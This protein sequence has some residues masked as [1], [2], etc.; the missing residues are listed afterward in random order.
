MSG[1][2][3]PL[4]PGSST[5][6]ADYAGRAGIWALYGKLTMTLPLGADSDSDGLPDFFE[7][8]FGFSGLSSTG[9][10]A[11]EWHID[12][13]SKST[14]LYYF[15]FTRTANAYRGYY[16]LIASHET[17]GWS[18]YFQLKGA[19]GTITFNTVN[20]TFTVSLTSFDGQET[21]GGTGS[22][23]RLSDGTIQCQGFTLTSSQGSSS[24]RTVQAFSLSPISGGRVAG[25]ITMTDGH[26]STPYAD[27]QS[28]HVEM[29]NPPPASVSSPAFPIPAGNYF[30]TR[31]NA[32]QFFSWQANATNASSYSFATLPAGLS[33]SAAGLISGTPTTPGTY[34]F[35]ITAS[36]ASGT[37]TREMVLYVLPSIGNL[38]WSDSFSTNPASRYLM[39]PA[40]NA[41]LGWSSGNGRLD[42]ASP[43]NADASQFGNFVKTIPNLS[44]S[45]GSSWEISVDVRLP[46]L[47]PAPDGSA[48]EAVGLGLVPDDPNA[49]L[50]SFDAN[51]LS[52]EVGHG[53]PPWE[54]PDGLSDNNFICAYA[55]SN[56]QDLLTVADDAP[57][58][59]Q[60]T[61]RLQYQA[62][63][64][65]LVTS[66]RTPSGSWVFTST[67]SLNPSVSGSVGAGWGLSNSSS[68]RVAMWA[69]SYRATGLTAGNIWLDN[70]T[71][72]SVSVVSPPTIDSSAQPLSTLA[73]TGQSVS[74]SVTPSGTGPFTYQWRLNGSPISG[75]TNSTYT[76]P[77]VSSSHAGSY[78]V[79]VSNSGGSV[80]SSAATLSLSTANISSFNYPGARS[81]Y[82][83]D[84]YGSQIVGFFDGYPDSNGNVERK[85]FLSQNGSWTL[86]HP[87]GSL[88]SEARGITASGTVVGYFRDSASKDHGY[89]YKN[90]AFTTQDYPTA[91]HTRIFGVDAS[92][93]SRFV[94]RF[95]DSQGVTRGFL[96][97]T[98]G[99]TP[100]MFPSAVETVAHG[101]AGSRVVGK[102][103]LVSDGAEFGFLWDGTNWTSLG[104]GRLPYA[105][106]TEGQAIGENLSP[107]STTGLAAYFVYQNGF[108]R[109]FTLPGSESAVPYGYDP[110]TQKISGFYLRQDQSGWNGLTLPLAF[111]TGSLQV[112]GRILTPS[113]TPFTNLRLVL[114]G[115]DPSAWGANA[116]SI[117]IGSTVTDTNGA[118]QFSLDRTKDYLIAA[119][120]TAT[121]AATGIPFPLNVF[122]D[123]FSATLDLGSLVAESTSRTVEVRLV[124][125]AA[126]PLAGTLLAN[127]SSAPLLAELDLV[128]DRLVLWQLSLL[129]RAAGL[130]F[131]KLTSPEKAGLRAQ[132]NR[133]W[134][135]LNW[136]NNAESSLLSWTF[137]AN[138]PAGLPSSLTKAEFNQIVYDPR[139]YWDDF[140]PVTF[141]VSRNGSFRYIVPVPA[142]PSTD[143]RIWDLPVTHYL[144][145]DGAIEIFL[146]LAPTTNSTFLSKRLDLNA[147]NL[148]AS[149]ANLTVR[150]APFRVSG[151]VFQPNGSTPL[152]NAAVNITG[153]GTG[154]GYQARI[155]TDAQGAFS[156]PAFA[157]S[158][159][160]ELWSGPI[161]G[162]A[163]VPVSSS[164]V[165]NV[166]LIAGQAAF[167]TSASV[168]AGGQTLRLAGTQLQTW[169]GVYLL[170]SPSQTGSQWFLSPSA[171]DP[172]LANGTWLELAIPSAVPTGTYYVGYYGY[173]NGIWT[174][175]VYQTP[176]TLTRNPAPLSPAA[177][178]S[179]LRGNLGQ[180]FSY[181]PVWSTSPTSYSATGLPA[182]LTNNPTTG[183]ISGTPTQA[184]Y[185]LVTQTASNS[186]GSTAFSFSLTIPGTS[187]SL[188]FSDDFS[189]SVTNRYMPLNFDSPA[190]LTITGGV[191]RYSCSS[192][193]SDGAIAALLP[194]LPLPLSSSWEISADVFMPSGWPTP[195][196]GVGLSLLP[197][198]STGTVETVAANRLNFKLARD[199]EDNAV[200]GNY[201]N[202][203]LYTNDVE[204]SPRNATNTTAT[205]AN[206]R[207]VYSATAKT[208]TAFYRT[209][210]S[211]AWTQLGSAQNLNPTTAGSL[212]QA[213]G[214]TTNS[215]LQLAFWGD[216]DATNGSAA[217]NICLDN[218]VARAGTVPSLSSQPTSTNVAAGQTAL[219]SVIATGSDPFTYQWRFNGTNLA[220]ATNAT[221]SLTNAQTN[222]AGPYSVVV[223]NFFG[224]VTSSVATLT[225]LTPPVVTNNPAF[226]SRLAGDS[227]I[228]SVA[229][230]GDGPFTYQWRLNGTNLASATNATL[231]LSG[232][233]ASQAGAYSVVVSGP[234][235]STTNG[236]A[237]VS[238]NQPL[239][240]F[241]DGFGSAIPGWIFLGETNRLTVTGGVLAAGSTLSSARPPVSLSL[242]SP[243]VAEVDAVLTSSAAGTASLA[244]SVHPE[245]AE[246]YTGVRP[247]HRL[248]LVLTPSGTN[249]ILQPVRYVNNVASNLPSVTVPHQAVRLRLAHAP[250]SGQLVLAWSPA[251]TGNTWSDLS[252]LPLNPTNS[253]VSNNLAT[254][255]NLNSTS[256]FRINLWGNQ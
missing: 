173:P 184:G 241:L 95:T 111:P 143:P 236:V 12:P 212:A 59:S 44:L 49:D 119:N 248:D 148:P 51:F 92:D 132:A 90:G 124:D 121:Q 85:G 37:D 50:S 239:L 240:P 234:G 157:S 156:F 88:R 105:V 145:G 204:L 210:P 26:P 171:R 180:A 84:S 74:F 233:V 197:Y 77:S 108:F 182:G 199:T 165:T 87:P 221:L 222:Q 159:E 185:F 113:N 188:P 46:L 251:S 191:A 166:S 225:I 177:L 125:D 217:Q 27:Y 172:N 190:S 65:S 31:A 5:Y 206:L 164:N 7:K 205:A 76:I 64:K 25:T 91:T 224:S 115:I 23:Q 18:G 131:G 152:T 229:A 213:W 127:A 93:D 196:A 72:Q 139:Y 69:D 120:P 109:T 61:L 170:E 189:S 253:S 11:D 122:A 158:G 133:I 40:A 243:W 227:T 16:T 245:S 103:R 73:A 187:L 19:T 208:L 116:S 24:A 244:L 192:S 130:T 161:F 178:P 8:S 155:R 75:A 146:G 123:P 83:S 3:R 174:N 96:R 175:I 80:T 216:S 160:W 15:T 198:T 39:V 17:L 82:G 60:A 220:A 33:G 42:Y 38:P 242:A 214:L 252:A 150:A 28:Y 9:T 223:S 163:Y 30:Y 41:S 228:L 4:S 237:L 141:E 2:L 129:Q 147:T 10:A 106:T 21:N 207:L 89:V 110:S 94:G 232:L 136:P 230:S 14:N 53:T 43:S 20:N 102:Y 186:G 86:L 140:N 52:L 162:N 211:A 101:V 249:R 254:L 99:W 48:Y 79:A 195:Y 81:T 62:S 247:A 168:I 149:P 57:S 219:F 117:P 135:E 179:G 36:N 100:L 128:S 151:R 114:H 215:S 231:S 34:W 29:S 32:G 138:S 97:T 47:S 137:L 78:T 181:T 203:A 112:S 246:T 1:E 13:S 134:S 71:V 56:W 98:Q 153:D 126:T 118:F 45:L 144:Y 22:Y 58:V 218:L 200:N 67:N 194:N 68:L 183:I 104:E 154:S 235:G 226:L 176:V 63:T 202:L 250:A 256:K 54:N 6:L 35:S 66:Y 55:R 238:V 169:P 193:S 209:N 107:W 70:F 255:W 167:V 142:A 201:F